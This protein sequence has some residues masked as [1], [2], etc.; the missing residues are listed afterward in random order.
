MSEVTGFIVALIA[1]EKVG[2]FDFMKKKT[3]NGVLPYDP[4][5]GKTKPTCGL[6]Y[7]AYRNPQTRQ[8]S[9]RYIPTG[10]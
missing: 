4:G 9:C 2:V 3:D 1:A 5:T 6:G 10:R 7:Y 8:W